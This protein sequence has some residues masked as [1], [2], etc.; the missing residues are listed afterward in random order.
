MLIGKLSKEDFDSP[1]PAG[2]SPLG[3]TYSKL[4]KKPPAKVRPKSAVTD[5]GFEV[6]L[7]DSNRGHWRASQASQRASQTSINAVRDHNR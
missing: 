1:R 7:D 6:E 5:Q 4:K 3:R 2:K